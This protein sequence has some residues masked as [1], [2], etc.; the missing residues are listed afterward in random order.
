MS[1][2]RV[3]DVGAA[4]AVEIDGVF[5]ERGR[6]ELRL[7]ERAGPGRAHGGARRE[8]LLHHLQAG[9][10]L[11]AEHLLAGGQPGFRAE[12]L[13]GVVGHFGRAEAGL[14]APDGKH[15]FGR[16]AVALFDRGQRFA[17]RG[18]ARAAA[19][20]DRAD[21]LFGE[22]VAGRRE[23]GLMLL[24]RGDGFLAGQDQVREFGVGFYAV[25]GGVEG[26]FGDAG[27]FGFGPKGFG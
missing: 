6:Q 20:G 12:H 2:W 17:E 3:P 25:E 16:H 18:R 13:E 1:G 26:G 7:A 4:V 5:Q 10:Q 19:L 15:Y 14:A 8:T 27:G 21:G 23:F 22:V 24:L 11:G 9:D